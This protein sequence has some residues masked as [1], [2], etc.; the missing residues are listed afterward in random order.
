MWFESSPNSAGPGLYV[1]SSQI[2]EKS[3]ATRMGVPI[4]VAEVGGPSA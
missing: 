3:A 1:E 2:F 4:A